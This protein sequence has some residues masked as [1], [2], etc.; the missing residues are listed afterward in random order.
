MVDKG[1]GRGLMILNV[2]S[3]YKYPRNMPYLLSLWQ[4]IFPQIVTQIYIPLHRYFLQ[5]NVD[6]PPLRGGVYVPYFWIWMDL[7]N[8]LDQQQNAAKVMLCGLDFIP[9][10]TSF[11]RCLPW[12]PDW[13]SPGHT[14][15]L[16]VGSQLRSQTTDSINCLRM[17]PQVTLALT[18]ESFG[19]I[20]DTVEHTPAVFTVCCV[21]S[22]PMGIMTNNKLF[23][24]CWATKL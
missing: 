4:I 3:L 7:C 14:K 6:T 24:L 19:C 20:P 18:F 2:P 8:C 9:D 21:N 17:N 13:R 15:R 5:T 22:W 11:V 10:F 23:Y 1:H 16:L 12:N